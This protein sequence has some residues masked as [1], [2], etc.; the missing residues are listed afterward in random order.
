MCR[1]IKMVSLDSVINVIQRRHHDVRS[2]H[3]ALSNDC[4]VHDLVCS[5][6]LSSSVL[7]RT[8]RWEL[9]ADMML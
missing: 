7:W 2:N 3:I 4:A 5:A 8:L 6:L 1:D 9:I